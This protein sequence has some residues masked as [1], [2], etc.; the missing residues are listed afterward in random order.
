MAGM[1]ARE[2]I[3][4]SRRH[5]APYR[6]C[7][8]ALLVASCSSAPSA[9]PSGDIQASGA[10]G[11]STSTAI[12]PPM[13]TTAGPTPTVKRAFAH[14]DLDA[15]GCIVAN[16][17][18][19]EVTVARTTGAPSPYISAAHYGPLA[20]QV[21]DVYL[22]RGGAALTIVYL[23]AGGWIAGSRADIPLTILDQLDRHRAVISVGYR[24]ANAS[25]WPA[26]S[27]DADRAIRWVR[28]HASDWGLD[29]AAL[30]VAG[31]SAGGQ[32]ALFL[33]AAPDL[34]PELAAVDPRVIGVVAMAAPAN[35]AGL[36]DDAFGR[37]VLE[38]LLGCSTTCSPQL[39]IDAS[40]STHVSA[41][42]PPLYVA[43]GAADTLVDPERNLVALSAQWSRAI[44]PSLVWVDLVD[45][46]GHNLDIDGVNVAAVDEFLTMLSQRTSLPQ[47]D[48]GAPR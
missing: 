33:A 8:V 22:P 28:L 26:Q 17:T 41:S 21:V 42:A 37:A 9:T 15:S 47:S 10:V 19:D 27:N 23:H 1:A 24:L 48:R 11:P 6:W 44:G 16:P 40:P 34:P 4:R 39:L 31:A 20:D 32:L 35:V 38:R 46:Q 25:P 36:M 14:C 30:V 29:P 13:T 5:I 2:S 45:N 18:P 3:P 12:D 43:V 7:V